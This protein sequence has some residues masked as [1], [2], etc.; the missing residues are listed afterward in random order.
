MVDGNPD[1]P[2]WRRV[3]GWISFPI[4]FLFVSIYLFRICFH[5]CNRNTQSVENNQTLANQK[6][7]IEKSLQ[8]LKNTQCRPCNKWKGVEYTV[9]GYRCF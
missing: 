9:L 5:Y 7:A 8:S 2:E 4:A 3:I 1:I 6:T